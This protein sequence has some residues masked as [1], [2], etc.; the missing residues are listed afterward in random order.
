MVEEAKERDL[1]GVYGSVETAVATGSV[2]PFDPNIFVVR[3]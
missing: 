2:K 3:L 1:L